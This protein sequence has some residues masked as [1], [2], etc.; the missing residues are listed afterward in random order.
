MEQSYNGSGRPLGGDRCRCKGLCLLPGGLCRCPHGAMAM[1]R[2]GYALR[3]MSRVI[4]VMVR[5]K[6]PLCSSLSVHMAAANL[7]ASS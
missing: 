7:P 5:S 6:G 2:W 1:C 3:L 4:S